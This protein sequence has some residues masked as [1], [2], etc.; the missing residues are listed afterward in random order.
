MIDAWVKTHRYVT[1]RE[2]VEAGL[3]EMIP[4]GPIQR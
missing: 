4:L 3:A 1:G 2:L